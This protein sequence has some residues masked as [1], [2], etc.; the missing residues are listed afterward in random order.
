MNFI[1]TANNQNTW[2]GV[3]VDNFDIGQNLLP[4][5]ADNIGVKIK[6]NY[7][8]FQFMSMEDSINEY[9]G[10]IRNH[11]TIVYGDLGIQVPPFS[12]N[13]IYGIFDENIG[14]LEGNEFDFWIAEDSLVVKIDENVVYN[15]HLNTNIYASSMSSSTSTMMTILFSNRNPYD[16]SY[17]DS[18]SIDYIEI[19]TCH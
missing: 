17:K 16:F 15:D 14:V 6:L 5:N 8:N 4:E 18:L 9:D 2:G 12:F 10:Y 1:F 3:G 13:T 19:Y 11:F 7:G